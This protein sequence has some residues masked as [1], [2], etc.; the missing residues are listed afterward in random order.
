MLHARAHGKRGTTQHLVR[1]KPGL[2]PGLAGVRGK[3]RIR[4]KRRARP[5]PHIAPAKAAT[6]RSVRGY[7]PF[8]LGRQTAPGPAAPGVGLPS[9]HVH[10][11]LVALH[12][13]GLAEP[14]LH[15][16]AAGDA[17]LLN[18][19]RAPAALAGRQALQPLPARR[20]PQL[21]PG[22]RGRSEREK[23]GL[24]ALGAGA[25]PL[26]LPEVRAADAAGA[27]ATQGTAGQ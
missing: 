17:N 20:L 18:I 16:R 5:L 25:L 22:H 19:A 27:G 12:A 24:R 11:G 23:P 1:T 26:G 14:G 6:R 8:H 9:A 4:L 21:R 7:F 3:T 2:R 15:H 13:H 10:G